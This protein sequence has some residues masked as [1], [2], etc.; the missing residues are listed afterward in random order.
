[1]RKCTLVSR[2]LRWFWYLCL[3]GALPLAGAAAT[4]LPYD[5]NADARADLQQ[6]LV[7]AKQ[8]DRKVLV[9][10][11][12]NWCPDCRLLDQQIEQGKTALKRDQFV[13]VKVDVGN[14]DRNLELTRAYG[15]VI[16]KGIPAA[17]IL[18]PDNQVVFRGRL[19]H[20]TSPYKRYLKPAFYAVVAMLAVSLLG[21][22]AY[23]LRR[24]AADQPTR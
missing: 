8:L 24:R 20:L 3:L 19:A 9:V 21:G 2:W 23:Y 18:T 22:L 11:G 12:A 10:F 14:F 4:A 15:N 7:R 16:R 17:V 6:A 5:E 13:M 1:M